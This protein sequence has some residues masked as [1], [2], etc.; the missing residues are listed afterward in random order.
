MT[1]EINVEGIA[2]DYPRPGQDNNSQGFRDNFSYIKIALTTAAGE[3]SDLQSKV[4]LKE[5]LIGDIAVDNDLLGN[6]IFNGIYSEFH[7][8]VH[9]PIN[10]N[11]T[12]NVSL[13][14]GP[15]QVFNAI[16][17]TT[18]RFE[19][20]PEEGWSKVTIELKGNQESEYTVN[21]STEA[22]GTIKKENSFPNPFTLPATDTT[23]CIEA[24]TRDGGSTVYLKYLGDW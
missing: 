16:A 24:W 18:L 23:R 12:V 1:S 8:K 13:V 15:Y 7:G 4:V 10:T 11:G 20:W 3:L 2:D 14:D 22:G 17:N 5:P 6:T 21:F 19:D 9:G